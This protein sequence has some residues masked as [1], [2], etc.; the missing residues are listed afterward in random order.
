MAPK[1]KPNWIHFRNLRGACPVCGEPAHVARARSGG[2]YYW[3]HDEYAPWKFA[4]LHSRDG[5]RVPMP[6]IREADVGRMFREAGE[7]GFDPAP[8][9]RSLVH[10]SKPVVCLDTGE[11]FDSISQAAMVIGKTPAS[12]S[13][14][15]RRGGKCAGFRWQFA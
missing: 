9:S 1:K 14:A 13:G 4:E 2:R 8:A 3:L 15:I 11:V 10:P 6:E 7:Q 12:I 5:K